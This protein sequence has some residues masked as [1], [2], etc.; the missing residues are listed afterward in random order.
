MKARQVEAMKKPYKKSYNPLA[1]T[2]QSGESRRSLTKSAMARFTKSGRDPARF[3]VSP[4]SVATS[5]TSMA[6]SGRLFRIAF[7]RPSINTAWLNP[8]S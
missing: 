2:G 1:K 5:Y 3:I 8:P 7:Q 6:T 4:V